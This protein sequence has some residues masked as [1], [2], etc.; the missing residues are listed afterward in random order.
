MIVGNVNENVFGVKHWRHRA[1]LQVDSGNFRFLWKTHIERFSSQPNYCKST[2]LA[3]QNRKDV[4]HLCGDACV[5]DV[6]AFG[7]L[8]N[9]HQRKLYGLDDLTNGKSKWRENV[10]IWWIRSVYL[11]QMQSNAVIDTVRWVR[12]TFEILFGVSLVI[13]YAGIFGWFSVVVHFPRSTNKKLRIKFSM[14]TSF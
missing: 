1:Q 4:R 9:V 3:D 14:G 2:H 13:F 12:V 11:S 10:S 8:V 6:N 5:D 7:Y